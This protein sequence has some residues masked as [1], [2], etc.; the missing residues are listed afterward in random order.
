[1]F[2]TNLSFFPAAEIQIKI[3]SPS[4]LIAGNRTGSG[5]ITKTGIK[6]ITHIHAGFKNQMTVTEG[7]SQIPLLNFTSSYG[8]NQK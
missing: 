3:L 6:K 4:S 8:N 2:S 7:Y 5:I 1:M